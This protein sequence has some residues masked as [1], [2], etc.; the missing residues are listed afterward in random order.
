MQYPRSNKAQF[1]NAALSTELHRSESKLFDMCRIFIYTQDDSDVLLEVTQWKL[2]RRNVVTFCDRLRCKAPI[3]PGEKRHYITGYNSEEGKFFCDKCIERYKIQPATMSRNEAGASISESQVQ[4][5]RRD[6]NAGRKKSLKDPSGAPLSMDQPSHSGGF[7]LPLLPSQLHV[8]VPTTWQYT[9]FSQ[10]PTL[11][12][13]AY[14]PQMYGYSS[15]H[16]QYRAN[17]QLWGSRAYQSVLE[18]LM[19]VKYKVLRVVPGKDKGV[20]VRNLVEGNP[21]I[22]ADATPLSLRVSGIKT[23]ETKIFSAL[24]GFAINWDRIVLREISNSVDLSREP[25]HVPC[26]YARCLTGKPRGKDG[27]PT[28]KKPT[29]PFEL[30]LY[31]DFDQWEGI[32]RYLTQKEIDKE[33]RTQDSQSR[34]TEPDNEP[35]TLS[36]PNSNYRFEFSKFREYY[37]FNGLYYSSNYHCF[38]LKPFPGVWPNH[39]ETYPYCNMYSRTSTTPPPSKRRAIPTYQSPNRDQLRDALAEGGSSLS[40]LS[41]QDIAL[42]ISDR[43]EFFP[44]SYRPLNKL[45]AAVGGG[46]FQGFTCDLGKAAEHR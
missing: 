42:T 36:A 27:A 2:Y 10:Q 12:Q 26:F 21:N 28:F 31:I 20:L 18:D 34:F 25:P 5:I 43:V 1:P 33:A 11:N 3:A 4:D 17:R 13:P 37:S 45:I 14:P 38:E 39:I 23:M 16:S 44:I 9:G 15:A 22:K 30:G 7:M 24:E 40:L 8:S 32:E 41:G 35:Q 29:K 6:V 19:T 46:K